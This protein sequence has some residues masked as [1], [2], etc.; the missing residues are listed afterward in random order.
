MFHAFIDDDSNAPWP[1]PD[2]A[3]ASPGSVADD[4]CDAT[5]ERAADVRQP[6]NTG[7]DHRT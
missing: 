6:T 2:S 5:G 1:I 3:M 7:R 4:V